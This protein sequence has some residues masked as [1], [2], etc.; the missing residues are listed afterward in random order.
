MSIIQFSQPEQQDNPGVYNPIF[1]C[2]RGEPGSCVFFR[3]NI[4]QMEY[5]RIGLTDE[6][7]I[8]C[9]HNH[10]YDCLIKVL[11]LIRN[12]INRLLSENLILNLIL[13]DDCYYHHDDNNNDRNSNNNDDDN[14]NEP[15]CNDNQD[16]DRRDLSKIITV[17]NALK[18]N[19]YDFTRCLNSIKL[20]QQEITISE[21]ITNWFEQNGMPMMLSRFYQTKSA[22]SVLARIDQN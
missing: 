21:E 22:R 9:Y 15:C 1:Y 12:K 18:D 11:Y 2:R 13:I 6:E 5:N 8:A 3:S 7:L 16:N 19:G 20:L 10:H 17:L 4:F 14:S